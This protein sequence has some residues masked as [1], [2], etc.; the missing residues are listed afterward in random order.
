MNITWL[1]KTSL[2]DAPGG[3]KVIKTEY[4]PAQCLQDNQSQNTRQS[5]VW[6]C[7]LQNESGSEC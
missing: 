7:P 1:L 6:R 4:F 2:C 5:T 3:F